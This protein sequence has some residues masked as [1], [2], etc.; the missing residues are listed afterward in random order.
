MESVCR[1]CF[2]AIQ[3]H[4]GVL[5]S[6]SWTAYLDRSNETLAEYLA[7]QARR[8]FD[9]DHPD[10]FAGSQIHSPTVWVVTVHTTNS[11]K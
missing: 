10:L 1:V 3:C 2:Q 6:A 4:V 9:H 11:L 7:W 8:L 5:T